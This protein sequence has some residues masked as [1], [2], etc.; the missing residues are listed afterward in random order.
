METTILYLYGWGGGA[1]S[2]GLLA[3]QEANL[4]AT[5]QTWHY[6]QINPT[7][8]YEALETLMQDVLQAEKVI[9]IGNS[10]GGY[11]ANYIA[12]KY[13][14]ES[15]L[16]N[17][18]LYPM[19]TLSTYNKVAKKYL[20]AYLPSTFTNK[21][22]WLYL[23]EHDTVIDASVAQKAFADCKGT[24]W[25]NEPHAIQDYNFLIE[26]VTELLV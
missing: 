25:L 23:S 3:L 12:E 21:K 10:L 5:I 4:N 6:D 13:N 9:V 20:E 7:P 16:I 2:K 15:V 17:P 14:L 19:E 8:N 22:K 1:H 18:S 24:Q 11:W 26:K